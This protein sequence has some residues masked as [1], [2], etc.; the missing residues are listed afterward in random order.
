M[1]KVHWIILQFSGKV[2]YF[3][4]ASFVLQK[5][6]IHE[7]YSELV[8]S[9]KQIRIALRPPGGGGGE[10][11]SL[12]IQKLLC[13]IIYIWQRCEILIEKQSD[14]SSMQFVI[15][16]NL[17]SCSQFTLAEHSGQEYSSPRKR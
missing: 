10:T 8:G 6:G 14:E 17:I 9:H 15:L 3:V 11:H 7:D 2:I 12:C 5:H 13:K 4:V 1:V 16:C